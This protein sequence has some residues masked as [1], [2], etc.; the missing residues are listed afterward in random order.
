M[1]FIF[2]VKYNYNNNYLFTIDLSKLAINVLN[3][4]Q[5]ILFIIDITVNINNIID[6]ANTII[7]INITNI[8]D[9][10]NNVNI[11]N[12]ININIISI[13]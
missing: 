9:V 10:I 8:D 6:I 13:I 1:L 5:Q 12:I 7:T 2:T 3:F 11:L 4:F